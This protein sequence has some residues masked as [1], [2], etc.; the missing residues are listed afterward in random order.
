[1]T[2][3]LTVTGFGIEA[4]CFTFHAVCCCL[5][6]CTLSWDS[7]IPRASAQEVYSTI[8][9]NSVFFKTWKQVNMLENRSWTLY[10]NLS[11]I[12]QAWVNVF[13][14][15]QAEP[16]F[17]VQLLSLEEGRIFIVFFSELFKFA[18]FFYKPT[19]IGLAMRFAVQIQ[20]SIMDIFCQQ[21]SYPSTSHIWSLIC[22]WIYWLD[23]F[24]W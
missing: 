20:G 11:A 15:L 21:L 22:W 7:I 24:Q 9:H 17:M 19:Y 5:S 6:V 14:G 3:C 8:S 18:L 12:A 13:W 2:F 16:L 23:S 10:F 4:D 1:M